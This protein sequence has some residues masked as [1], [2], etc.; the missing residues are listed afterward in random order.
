MIM[1]NI[2]IHSIE[3][4]MLS[5][6]AFHRDIVACALQARDMIVGQHRYLADDLRVAIEAIKTTIEATSPLLAGNWVTAYVMPVQDHPQLLTTY[7]IREVS[8]DPFD[9]FS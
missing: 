9:V 3:L 7:E 5:I 1:Q 4:S 2:R 6:E 8:S